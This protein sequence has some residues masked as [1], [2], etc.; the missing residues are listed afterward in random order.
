MQASY[1]L[2]LFRLNKCILFESC[3]P[4]MFPM[5]DNGFS[6]SLLSFGALQ[7]GGK[8]NPAV[9]PII[10]GLRGVVHHG[11]KQSQYPVKLLN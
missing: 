8:D 4:I 6:S 11:E 1:V 9:D 10:H 7:V 5:N 3:V 2:C